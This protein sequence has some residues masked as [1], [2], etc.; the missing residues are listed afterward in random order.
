MTYNKLL[1]T[2]EFYGPDTELISTLELPYPPLIG[3]RIYFGGP[4]YVV[5]NISWFMKPN[6]KNPSEHIIQVYLKWHR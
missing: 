3:Q 5:E 6:A 4:Y 2:V 1:Y